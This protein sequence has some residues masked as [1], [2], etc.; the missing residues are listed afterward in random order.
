MPNEIF[1]NNYVKEVKPSIRQSAEENPA[2]KIEQDV[3][4]AVE[5]YGTG[6]VQRH[7]KRYRLKHDQ[8]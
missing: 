2:A 4:Q 1:D 5:I 7:E 8:D 3:Q 6:K